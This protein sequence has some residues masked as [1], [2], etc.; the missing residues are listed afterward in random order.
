MNPF[1]FF[2]P[3][4]MVF[5][6]GCVERL[7]PLLRERG[8]DSSFIITDRGVLEAGCLDGVYRSLDEAGIVHETFDGVEQNPT[9]GNVERALHLLQECGH[10]SLVAVGG[11][12]SIDTAKGVL[13]LLTEDR[14]IRD[15]Y[16]GTLQGR[17]PIPMAAIPTT[18]GTGSEVTWSAVITNPQA[19]VK[20]TIRGECLYPKLALI[21]P[22]LTAS[23][24]A[25]ITASTGMDALTHA[26]EAYTTSRAHALSDGLAMEATYLIFRHL[27]AAV[28]DPSDIGARSGMS[29]ASTLAGLAFSISGLGMVHGMAEPL[30]G[31]LNVPHGI[32]NS[33]LLPYCLEFNRPAVEERLSVLA[34]LVGVGGGSAHD[35]AQALV[36]R[37]RELSR[38]VGIPEH[39][40]GYEVGG[41]ELDALV[42][43]AMGNSCLPANPREVSRED[44]RGIYHTILDTHP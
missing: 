2:V 24:P 35:S 10:G 19:R 36:D 43:D 17:A 16:T 1:E 42:E 27:E 18:A 39:L 40:D 38:Q 6:V 5:R 29:I 23:M 12:S 41:E 33:V 21:D 14:D 3:T 31:R 25:K 28:E 13:A 11:G 37:V 32:A 7:G 34:R 44:L 22:Q 4:R 9:E 26:L 15:L 30:G 8:A 20:E